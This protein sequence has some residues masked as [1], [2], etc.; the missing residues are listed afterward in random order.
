MVSRCARMKF[1]LEKEDRRK[2][3]IKFMTSMGH[4]EWTAETSFPLLVQFVRGEIETTVEL[5][6]RIEFTLQA[7]ADS[8][9]WK[10]NKR[11]RER[12]IEKYVK[13]IKKGE[14]MVS[15]KV[16]ELPS[17]SF[18]EITCFIFTVFAAFSVASNKEVGLT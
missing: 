5:L 7:C 3:Y 10:W 4:E 9:K 1:W 18:L 17:P 11:N 16:N 6:N 15:K 2:D 13:S 14:R 12:D 8:D